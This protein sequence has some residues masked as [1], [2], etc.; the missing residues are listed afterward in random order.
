VNAFWFVLIGGLLIAVALLGRQLE[1]LP[2]SPAIVYLLAGL[3]LGP[4]ALDALALHPLQ[5]LEW[6]EVLGEVALLIALFGAGM[7]LRMPFTDLRWR[8]PLR[9]ATRCMAVTVV[10][11]ALFAWLLLDFDAGLALILG[12]ALAPTGPVLASEL[13]LRGALDHDRLHFDLMAEGG[14]NIGLA[15]PFVSLG[16]GVLGAGEADFSLWRW[17]TID[18]FWSVAG[19][20]AIGFVVGAAVAAGGRSLRARFSHAVVFDEFLLLGVMAVSYGAASGIHAQELLAVFAAGLALRRADE[21]DALGAAGDPRKLPLTPDMLG[22][23]GRCERMAEVAIALLVGVMIS[24]GYWSVMGLAVAGI[25]FV[26]VRPLSV[27]AAVVGAPPAPVQLGLLGWFGI[28]RTGP[29]YYGLFAV[30]IG[31]DQILHAEAEQLLSCIFTVI[32]SSILVHGIPAGP[33]VELY[34][35][36]RRRDRA[37]SDKR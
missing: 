30:S 4:A 20:L 1:R 7:R 2:V 12:G 36:W 6:L 11:V 21:I 37:V 24:S 9:L 27:R 13:Q 34:R 15:F 23:I 8:L 31:S 5:H 25:L 18:V 22:V 28:R 33:L 3:L 17:L 35:S 19:G 29:F 16:L 10:G 14:L 32:A 26:V